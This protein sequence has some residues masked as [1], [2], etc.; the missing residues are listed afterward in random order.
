MP[1]CRGNAT[2]R[3]VRRERQTR[4]VDQAV[5]PFGRKF[6]GATQLAPV[7]GELLDVRDLVG[8]VGLEQTIEPCGA[9]SGVGWRA[10]N[11]GHELGD[12]AI[13]GA[14]GRAGRTVDVFQRGR[15]AFEA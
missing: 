13:D 3:L 9:C 7:L 8:G 6:P 4:E 14:A 10:G 12:G 15:D 1:T 2:C 5:G 11:D